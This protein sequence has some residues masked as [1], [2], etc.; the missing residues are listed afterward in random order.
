MA[1]NFDRF[2]G[3][4]AA[5]RPASG[6]FDDQIVEVEVHDWI[7]SL[8]T[9][10][11]GIREIETNKRA[12]E[13][14]TTALTAAIFQ[15]ERIDFDTG[16]E[17]FLE[18]FN[19]DAPNTSLASFFQKMARNE[20]GR[21]YQTGDGTL[22]FEN[23][24]HR[25]NIVDP[26][27]ALNG[28]M[29]EFDIEYDK[30]AIR[31]I[32]QVIVQTATT[33][34]ADITL[35]SLPGAPAILSGQT[36][37]FECAYTDPDTEVKISAIDVDDPPFYEFGSVQNFTSD[38][39]HADLVVAMEI[40]AN[41]AKVFL[42]NTAATTGYLNDL[43]LTGKGIHLNDP[44]LIE[45]RNED[46]IYSGIGEQ[47]LVV[48]LEQITDLGTAENRANELLAEYGAPIGRPIWLSFCAS[49]DPVLAYAA[50]SIEPSTRFAVSES[51]TEAN[52]DYYV[53]RVAFRMDGPYL[54]V[55]I[56]ASPEGD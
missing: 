30:A 38:D 35:W 40:G 37:T 6:L 7:A 3:R 36:L 2:V 4:I 56:L 32:I 16:L 27:F 39:M 23:R 28:E 34:A 29:S 51:I 33:D 55:D 41:K 22:I 25:Q 24:T 45:R 15:P 19:T 8:A 49:Q 46:S 26:A 13:A 20:W 5:I 44:I 18:V 9:S 21:I 11:L 54:W 53:E 43:Q 31:N 1:Y 48:W 10:E 17:T 14:L 50:L 52:R 42:T 12:D 47:R